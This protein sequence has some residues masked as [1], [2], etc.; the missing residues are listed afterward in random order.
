MNRRVLRPVASKT[1][2]TAN[3]IILKDKN[4]ACIIPNSVKFNSGASNFYFSTRS[5]TCYRIAL[6]KKFAS[7]DA[8]NLG[9]LARNGELSFFPFCFLS[10]RRH[11]LFEFFGK[12][13]SARRAGEEI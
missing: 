6:P 10:A 9:L 7:E 4:T 8:E 1:C 13:M 5:L 3:G 2:T 12:K 11:D